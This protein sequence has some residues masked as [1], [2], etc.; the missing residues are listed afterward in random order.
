MRAPCPG[1][2][3]CAGLFGV[4]IPFHNLIPDEY[5]N[6]QMIAIFGAVVGPLLVMGSFVGWAVY[7]RAITF[8]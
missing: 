7:K 6:F 4:N 8:G 3:A 5:E 1:C 2:G